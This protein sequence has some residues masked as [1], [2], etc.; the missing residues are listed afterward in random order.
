MEAHTF[1]LPNGDEALTIYHRPASLIG[2]ES[3][4]VNFPSRRLE[5]PTPEALREYSRVW[6]E[7]ADWLEKKRS[8]S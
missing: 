4:S 1:D 2:P 8:D 6:A 5:K 3:F 7:A